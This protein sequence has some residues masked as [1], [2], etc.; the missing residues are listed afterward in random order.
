MGCMRRFGV[1]KVKS[2]PR[3]RYYGGVGE[4]DLCFG[5]VNGMSL[6][7]SW[8]F[9]LK[10]FE[11]LWQVYDRA[12]EE[13]SQTPYYKNTVCKCRAAPLATSQK[14]GEEEGQRANAEKCGDSRGLQRDSVVIYSQSY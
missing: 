4:P 1:S 6:V 14:K 11:K 12:Q 2:A 5:N 10:N 3:A 9:G 13:F 8:S 7:G